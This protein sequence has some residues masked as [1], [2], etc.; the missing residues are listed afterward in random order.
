VGDSNRARIIRVLAP[1]AAVFPHWN[2][3]K[4]AV[5]VYV[6]VLGDIPAD[7]L[8]AS[9]VHL[10]SMPR[11]FM[12]PP[13]VIRQTAFELR[14]SAVSAPD[15]FQAWAEV[16][17]AI[18]DVGSY[19]LPEFS[20]PTIAE[21]VRQIGGWRLVCL[22][23]DATADR[24]RFLQAFKQLSERG[25]AETRMLPAVREHVQLLAGKLSAERQ[26]DTPKE[27]HE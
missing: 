18:S 7:L 1:L 27:I 19:R 16:T 3:A 25:E 5:D 20:H 26:L 17:R 11:E 13:G 21:A 24:A 14:A 23:E 10:A 2:P 6:A 8:Q 12:P 9:I 22:S 15:E 4:E